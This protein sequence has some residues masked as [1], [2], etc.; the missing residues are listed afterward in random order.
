MYRLAFLSLVQLAV[1][2]FIAKS[3]QKPPWNI[4]LANILKSECLLRFKAIHLQDG[5]TSS[6]VHF[7]KV[8]TIAYCVLLTSFQTMPISTKATI[9]IRSVCKIGSK[10]PRKSVTLAS[11]RLKPLS[12]RSKDSS[13]IVN[14]LDEKVWTVLS[15]N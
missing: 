6:Q 1:V 13:C 2:D 4:H 5:V 9:S 8:Q 7:A 12:L 14:C 11:S 10:D 15:Y 3:V